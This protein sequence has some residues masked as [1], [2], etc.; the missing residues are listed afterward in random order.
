MEINLLPEEIKR[1]SRH[2]IMPEFGIK[3]QEKLKDSSV[4]IVGVGGLGCPLALYLAAAGVGRIG[5][6]DYDKVEESNLQRQILYTIEDVGKP[7]A[8]VAKE[9]LQK[10]NPYIKV[11]AYNT[12]FKSHNAK[13]IAKDYD[14][15]IDGTDN[16]PTRYLVNDLCVLTGKVNVYGSVFRFDGQVTVFDAKRGPCY[17]CLY[18]SP[19]PAG[20]VPSCAEGGVLGILPG[21]I[22]IL[23]ATEAIKILSGRGKPLIGKLLLF[24]ALGLEF[25][26]VKIR[27]NPHCPICSKE[28]TI[29]ELIDYEEFCGMRVGEEEEITEKEFLITPKELYEDLKKGKKYFLLDV[30]LPGEYE[31]CHIDGSVLIPL[32]ELPYSLDKIPMDED[33]VAICHHGARS[34]RAVNI[35][36]EAG[37]KRVKNLEGGID[38]WAEEVDPEMPRY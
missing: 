37:Y 26:E 38:R 2:L 11:E 32:S 35:L 5:I 36:R 20:M 6:V 21:I 31:I 33:I 3:A 22:G 17:R 28:A 13:E 4:L 19:P 29:K 34:A 15:I 7:K 9:K 1:Y 18:P 23:Q 30:R 16:F 12:L 24:D 10:L 8:E 14:I 25:R 27:K